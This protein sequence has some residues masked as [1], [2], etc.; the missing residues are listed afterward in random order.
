MKENREMSFVDHLSELRSRVVRIVIVFVIALIAGFAVGQ[1]IIEYLMHV[2]PASGFELN[3][4]SPWDSLRIYINVA[5]LAALMIS[6]PFALYQIWRFVS[7]GLKPHER[8]A[9]LNY[10]PLAALLGICGLAFAYFVVFPLT[11]SFTLYLAQSMGLTMTYGI[12][13]YFSFMFNILIPV[14]L[15]FELP[16]I[17]LFLT[18]IHILKPAFLIKIRKTAYVVLVIISTLI[19][20]PDL[21]SALIVYLPLL[22]LYEMS[23]FFSKRV[24]KKQQRRLSLEEQLLH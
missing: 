10:I 1:P 19:T 20:P 18:T 24:H 21:V 12:T 22:L 13:Q 7:P 6:L 8:K 11:F 14:T 3:V 9:A 15:V 4:F 5:M 16:V 17:V 2:P 23:I